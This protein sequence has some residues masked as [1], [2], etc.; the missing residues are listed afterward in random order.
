MILIQSLSSL[1]IIS[2]LFCKNKGGKKDG[3]RGL[4]CITQSGTMKLSFRIFTYKKIFF[5]IVSK[6][7]RE[8]KKHKLSESSSSQPRDVSHFFLQTL[9]QKSSSSTVAPDGPKSIPYFTNLKYFTYQFNRNLAYDE[10]VRVNG[11]TPS[12][13]LSSL[14]K[15]SFKWLSACIR[16]PMCAQSILGFSRMAQGLV[17]WKHPPLIFSSVTK[18]FKGRSTKVSL[19]HLLPG[20]TGV[21]LY[22]CLRHCIPDHG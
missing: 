9:S 22:A 3:S 14:K 6:E 12:P 11:T 16:G 20:L 17:K 18:T 10:S 7:E 19:C 5:C 2:F 21:T 8:R 15:Q 1:I 13:W 4:T